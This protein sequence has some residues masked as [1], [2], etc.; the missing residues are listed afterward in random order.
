ML[1]YTAP[2]SPFA[3]SDGPKKS[4]SAASN[5]RFL[6]NTSSK[7][8]LHRL[9][10]LIQQRSMDTDSFHDRSSFSPSLSVSTSFSSLPSPS[11]PPTTLPQPVPRPSYPSYRSDHVL[12]PPSSE[13]EQ[14]SI[15]SHIEGILFPGD[16]VGEGIPLQGELLRLV[17][18]QSAEQVTIADYREPA[19]EFEVVRKL[20]TGSYA[21]VYL[22]RRS[23]YPGG[24]LELDEA[25]SHRPPTLYGREYAVKLLSKAD[26]DEEEL[27]AQLTEATIHQSIPVHHNIVTLHRT[28][29]TSAFLLLLLEFVPGQDLFYFLEQARD[30]YDVDPAADPALT[31]TPPTPGLLSSLHPSQLLSHT[32]LRLIA[33]MF[34]QMCEAVAACHD[35][36]VFHRDIK[37]ENF[38]VTDG[39]VL[40]QDGI[41]ERKVIV[42]LSD[43]GLSTTD[44]ISSDM[45]CGSAPYMSFECRNNVAPVYKPRAADVWS[46]GI[47]LINMLYHYNPW[48]DTAT[49]ACSSFDLYLSCP[50]EFFMRRFAG[51]TPAVANFLVENVFCILKDP[52]DD[53]QRIGARDFGVWVR[54]LPTLMGASLP[55]THT[56]SRV[57]STTSITTGHL[58]ASAPASRRPSSRQASVAGG[59]P[60]R[61]S[62][63]LRPPS[64]NTSV[65]PMLER[66]G[67]DNAL[68]PALDLVLNEEDE[69]EEEEEEQRQQRQEDQQVE[70]D[71]RSPSLRSISMTK[72]RKRGRK[73]K[74]MTPSTDHT[75]TS[76]LLASASQTLA[77]EL[78]RQTRSA[79]ATIPLFP[80][81]PS[82]QPVSAPVSLPV[83][84]KKPSRWKLSFGKSA[85]EAAINA[86]SD[87]RSTNSNS[88][89]GSARA[90]NVTNLI[91]G[92]NPSS[93]SPVP[94]L[95]Q[96]PPSVSHMSNM[97]A[98][99]RGR[100]G[101][102]ERH[103]QQVNPRRGV[104]PTSTRSGRPLASSSS[105]M[106]SNNWRSSMASTNTSTSA[107]T[108]YSNQSTRSVSTFATSV[109]TSSASSST[110][111]R[112]HPGPTFPSSSS[113]AS[114]VH[115][116]NGSLNSHNSGLPRRPPPNVKCTYFSTPS[117]LIPG[118]HLL[119]GRSSVMNGV[120]WELSGAP[121]QLHQKEM[122]IFGQPPLPRER[123]RA[124]RGGGRAS[125]PLRAQEARQY[126]QD[127]ATSTTDLAAQA[128]G[129]Q[130]T[131]LGQGSQGQGQGQDGEAPKMPKAQINALAKMLSAL[132]R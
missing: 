121:R 42:K 39:W 64:R 27:V 57:P 82:P 132:R 63:V 51:M 21:V 83:V 9:A 1:Q 110:N 87:S 60:R 69:D 3:F 41:R 61:T 37:P 40:N 67:S 62:V 55:A 15:S 76:E 38:I 95:P 115:S 20:G 8:D 111:W 124:G 109:S 33:S 43:F 75:Q 66:D 19:K 59:S 12:E 56:H 23:Y 113:L 49:G 73:G 44:S 120:P 112:K 74:G 30:H 32:R 36:S 11:F 6:S 94:P 46:L 10:P 104:S 91:M 77:R 13:K 48:T 127:A 118:M 117:P 92:L 122:D 35:A 25:S 97:E 96:S 52:T 50:T 71:G 101:V 108:R 72:R 116:S 130:G 98:H 114:S 47:V 99:V 17:P 16:V 119:T 86:R 7:L 4:S 107:F 18:N 129:Q 58:L 102:P 28:L 45:D 89:S 131:G 29:E 106:A 68:P 26:L 31:H 22:V 80:D 103:S 85:G 2:P 126:R 65:K 78:S 5:P 125:S 100:D 81:V 34:A 53:S 54:D 24:R 93:F 14:L 105:S 88:T 123:K 128:Q 84:T 79:S 90:A 70:D